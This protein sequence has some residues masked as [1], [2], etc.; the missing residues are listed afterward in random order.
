MAMEPNGLLQVDRVPE[1]RD[2]VML[3]AFAGWNDASDVATHAIRTLRKAWDAE[4]FAQIDPEEFF[5]FTVSRPVISLGPTGQRSLTWP[6]NSFFVR[7]GGE[8][9][10]DTILLLG[11]EPGLK[12]RLFCRT[13]CQ[14][15]ETLDVS[16]LVTLG[17]LLAD[18]PH[19]LQPRLTGF[20]TSP[21][22]LPR[23]RELGVGLSTY[24]GPT[25]ILGAL[26]DAWRKT[27]RPSISLWGNVP[28]YISATPNPQVA[29]ALLRGVSTLLEV[30]LPLG[31]LEARARAFGSQIDEA[32][33]HNPE[34]LD[35][36]R[37]LE[38]HFE[39]GTSNPDA[40]ELI[41]ELERYLRNRRPTT[42]DEAE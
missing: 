37:Q 22:L 14:F 35:Y 29:L 33:I 38:Q 28:H 13:I 36:V 7:K 39:A 2:P 31:P 41:E 34:A 6:T 21:D 15:S 11:T 17:G 19:T 18:V 42:D 20:T 3:A 40:P 8:G 23:L 12:W 30:E 1:L 26:H 24:E 25:G 9:Q 5:D 16:C 27:G 10:K 4:E 32:L